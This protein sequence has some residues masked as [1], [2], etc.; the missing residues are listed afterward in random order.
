MTSLPSSSTPTD[1]YAPRLK[2]AGIIMLCLIIVLAAKLWSLQMIQGKSYVEMSYNNRVRFIRLPPSRGRILDAKGR[3]LAEN[4]PSF[5]FSVIPGE[6]SNPQKVIHD[7]SPILGMTEERMR[8]LINRSRS[9]PKFLDFPIKKNMT[10]EEVSLLKSLGPEVKGTVLEV[11]PVRVYPFHEV[12]CHELGTLGEISAQELAKSARLGYRPGDMI[13]KSGIEKEYQAYLKGEEG[14][15]QVEID[16][17]GHQLRSLTRKQ[18]KAG[19]DVVLTVDADFQKYVESVFVHRAGS[20]VAVD[21]DTGRILAIVSKPGFDLNLFSPAITEREWKTLNSDSL[22]PLENRSIRGLYSPASTFKIVTAAAGLGEH[23]ITPNNTFV[24]KGQID[25]EGQVYRCWKPG[26]HGTIALHRAIVESCDVYFYTL[27]LKLGPDRIAKYAS[28]FGLGTPTGIGL[29]QEL[30]GLVPNPGWKKRTYGDFWKD[31][32]TVTY[33]I[34]QGYLTATPI[35]LAMMTAIV[36]NGGKLLRPA[37]VQKIERPDGSLIFE[38]A[39]VVRWQVPIDEKDLD[40]LQSA[41]ADVV[42]NK[43]GTGTRCRIPGINIHAKSGTSQVIH[44]KHRIKDEDRIPY[45]ERPHAIFVAYVNDRPKKIALAVVVEHG[46]G[47]G[48][49]AAPIA[50]KIIARYYGVPDPRDSKTDHSPSE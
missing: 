19:A 45:H 39:P 3:V 41:M 24:C 44:A 46:G 7:V 17:K 36:A 38:H 48:A 1:Y 32:E 47:G 27:G 13:G 43:E 16:A 9:I 20:V 5:T 28:L 15:E 31:G 12:L 37:L 21:P 30:P 29:P 8:G 42:N 10:L 50:R 49:S 25:L 22:H 14:W 40:E 26:G 6:L 18:P 33:A 23:V 11:K 4:R 35:Q 2:L 34:G